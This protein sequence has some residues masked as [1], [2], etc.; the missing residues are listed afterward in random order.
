MVTGNL[1]ENLSPCQQRRRGLD[2]P[3]PDA[4]PCRQKSLLLPHPSPL[5]PA[6]CPGVRERAGMVLE[7]YTCSRN[8]LTFFLSSA[9]KL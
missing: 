4:V 7:A 9:T 6:D 1:F 3:L 5:G 8:L 2:L